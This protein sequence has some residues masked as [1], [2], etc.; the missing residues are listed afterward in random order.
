MEDLISRFDGSWLMIGD[1]NSVSKSSEKKGGSAVVLIHR[2]VFIILC[3]RLGPLIWG[4]AAPNL[5][6]L[7]K[8]LGGQM[9]VKGWIEAYVMLTGKDFFQMWGLGISQPTT[10]ITTLL[11]LT[12]TWI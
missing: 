1:L 12:L 4:L 2:G 7:T 5:L 11:L 8:E 3:L 9:C 10:L 6:G